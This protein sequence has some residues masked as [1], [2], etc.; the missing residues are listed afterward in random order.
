MKKYIALAMVLAVLLLGGCRKAAAS[1][2]ESHP[3]TTKPVEPSGTTVPT[4]PVTTVPTEPVTTVPTEPVTTVP[5]GPVTTPPTEPM[6]PTTTSPGDIDLPE[7]N[8]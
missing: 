2:G 1:S 8:I 5:T 4:E 7:I 6:S 3:T